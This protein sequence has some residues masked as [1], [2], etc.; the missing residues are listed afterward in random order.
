MPEIC[1]FF[2]ITV[3][4]YYNDHLPPH[5][6]AEY[7]EFEAVY[8]IESLELLRG[9]LPRRAHGMLV[10]WALGQ[11]TA[12]RVNWERARD[13]VPLEAIAPLD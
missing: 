8:A 12:L 3:F 2:G 7:G 11:R 4:M 5:F 6:H 13:Q 10:E 9:S 1:R